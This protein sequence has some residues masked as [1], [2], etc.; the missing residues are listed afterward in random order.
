MVVAL[1]IVVNAFVKAVV[2][3]VIIMLLL[4]LSISLP[5]SVE[6]AVVVEHGLVWLAD[7]L[8]GHGQVPVGARLAAPVIHL[9][10]NYSLYFNG[11]IGFESILGKN[12]FW[13]IVWS[14]PLLPSSLS[15]MLYSY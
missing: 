6:M 1:C 10:H 15:N 11:E 14:L 5:G 2:N 9:L 13:V 8:V 4:L 7:G 12:E 3:A